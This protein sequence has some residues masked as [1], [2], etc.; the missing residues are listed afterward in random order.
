MVDEIAVLRARQTRGLGSNFGC[1]SRSPRLL[2][3]REMEGFIAFSKLQ[4]KTC[5]CGR[6]TGKSERQG[7]KKVRSVFG[8][9]TREPRR[10]ELR[11]DCVDHVYYR[12]N[13]RDEERKQSA[14]SNGV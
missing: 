1:A 4:M 9:N 5:H 7:E 10:G 11:D 2:F 12:E 3:V 6:S 14:T 13:G 8:W